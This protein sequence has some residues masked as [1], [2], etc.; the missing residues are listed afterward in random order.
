MIAKLIDKDRKGD[1]TDE[2]LVRCS[3]GSG[4]L[5]IKFFKAS[6]EDNSDGCIELEYFAGP[7]SKT[8]NNKKNIPLVFMEP[9]IIELFYKSIN[10]YFSDGMRVLG[11]E[12]GGFVG[13]HHINADGP[14]GE[15]LYLFIMGFKN[16][17][18]TRAFMRSHGKKWR[19]LLWDIV[20]EPKEAVKFVEVF[21]QK[22]KKYIP[23]AI[24]CDTTD[25]NEPEEVLQN[26]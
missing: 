13:I 9:K 19:K 3:S 25:Q 16:K 8:K 22:I 18:D 20:L 24:P 23:N 10:Q 26:G 1:Y 6:K 2:I 12:D 14:A 5:S 21:N 15:G 7:F 11:G 4:V 17:S